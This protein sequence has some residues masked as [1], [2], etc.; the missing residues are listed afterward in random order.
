MLRSLVILKNLRGI[1]YS[2]AISQIFLPNL[3]SHLAE[4]EKDSGSV[5]CLPDL[6][7]TVLDLYRQPSG[8][9]KD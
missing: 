9:A 3:F 2:V 6:W 8:L 4:D 1:L 7:M 5:E